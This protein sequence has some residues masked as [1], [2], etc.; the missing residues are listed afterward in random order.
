MP[1]PSSS[2]A[3]DPFLAWASPAPRSLVAALAPSPPQRSLLA[4]RSA[5]AV[6]CWRTAA[7]EP[8]ADSSTA[9]NGLKGLKTAQ[10]D[11][12]WHKKKSPK[13]T[14]ITEVRPF[15]A[16]QLAASLSSSSLS[17]SS[18]ALSLVARALSPSGA[19]CPRNP[20]SPHPHCSGNSSLPVP[21]SSSAYHVRLYRTDR[22][23][24]T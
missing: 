2:R 24:R 10:N 1:V 15:L 18:P 21:S 7:T 4:A 23:S 5:P 17:L 3:P 6:R 13:F 20:S 8:T 16:V 9:Q 22:K 11:P 14:K 19:C 12:K